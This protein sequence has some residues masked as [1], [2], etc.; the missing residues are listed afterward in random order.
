M[1]SATD[2]APNVSQTTQAHTT[3]ITSSQPTIAT[4]EHTDTSIITEAYNSDIFTPVGST[5][6]TTTNDVDRFISFM[7]MAFHLVM[8]FGMLFV[9][10]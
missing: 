8:L 7:G 4:S 6:E 5:V 10:V 2:N 3:K 1:D 9:F